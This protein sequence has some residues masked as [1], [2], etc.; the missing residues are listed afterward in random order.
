[1]KEKP[2]EIDLNLTQLLILAEKKI[3]IYY[4]RVSMFKTVK[5]NMENIKSPNKNSIGS[6]TIFKMKAIL[7]KINVTLAMARD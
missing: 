4:N 3:K 6:I 5:R 7:D 2:T 1:M